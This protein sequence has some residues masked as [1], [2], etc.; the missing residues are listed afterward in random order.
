MHGTRENFA[1]MLEENEIEEDGEAD[2]E[3]CWQCEGFRPPSLGPTKSEEAEDSEMGDDREEEEFLAA[4]INSENG[5]SETGDRGA[6]ESDGDEYETGDDREMA[7]AARDARHGCPEFM[8]PWIPTE[9]EVM[10]WS[11]YDSERLDAE[12]LKTE[13]LLEEAKRRVRERAESN[14]ARSSGINDCEVENWDEEEAKEVERQ[15]ERK[16]RQS[17]YRGEK[18]KEKLEAKKIAKEVGHCRRCGGVNYEIAD[19][20]NCGLNQRDDT[21]EIVYCRECGKW[22]LES[23]VLCRWCGKITEMGKTHRR[24]PTGMIKKDC[25]PL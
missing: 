8:A 21:T 9:L 25:P 5:E 20:S 16:R 1:F 15:K 3:R 10:E 7:R 11:Q 17:Q 4:L 14:G 19:C 13:K 24:W 12:I 22:Q 18:M 6:K 23:W 2:D